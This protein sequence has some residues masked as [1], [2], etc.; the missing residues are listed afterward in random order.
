MRQAVLIALA[1]GL[2]GEV[3]ESRQERDSPAARHDVRV[4]SSVSRTAVWVGDPVELVVEFVLPSQ[5][6]VIA[7][8][9]ASD[10][11]KLEGLEVVTTSVE[12]DVAAE[13]EITQ[14]FRYRLATYETGSP[15][16]RIAAWPVRYYVRRAGE[17]PE[18]VSPAGEVQVP[19][20]IVARRS[21]LPDELPGLDLR[22]DAAIADAGGML[23]TAGPIGIGLIVLAAAP[24]AI[25]IAALI[26][27][28]RSRAPRPHARAV[29]A[30]ARSA[31]EEVRAM[32]VGS[33]AGRREA[34]GRLE[35]AV[36]QH[37]TDTRGI[38]AH[39][40]SAG[41]VATRLQ[42]AGAPNADDAGQL[43]AEC[44]RARYAP[45][46]R[47]PTAERFGDTLGAAERMFEGSAGSERGR[48]ARAE[49][50]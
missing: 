29:R 7:E 15:T 6:D 12:R 38:P 24:L 42:A 2:A 8:D 13:G 20:A 45:P 14:R 37:L 46:D 19:G 39:A 47:L 41:E 3:A 5:V 50:S 10:K 28:P 21:T 40:L 48:T 36:R 9:L 26:V 35:R 25:W 17:R 4:R 31:L 16:L 33:E 27:G 18:D 1:I 49:P 30:Q 23:R 43:L 22:T 44:E 11:L 32:D 34:Y